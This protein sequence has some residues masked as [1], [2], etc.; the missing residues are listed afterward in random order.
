MWLSGYPCKW[1]S[2]RHKVKTSRQLITL[3]QKIIA[4]LRNRLNRMEDSP[5]R[6]QLIIIL[7]EKEKQLAQILPTQEEAEARLKEMEKPRSTS[8][9]QG[10][11]RR[12]QRVHR[13]VLAGQRQA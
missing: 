6:R 8:G 13:P 11:S 2:I 3:E 5:T 7:Q 1:M 12:R 9:Y 10:L 4:E